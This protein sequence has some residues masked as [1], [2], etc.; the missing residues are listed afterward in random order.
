M[1]FVHIIIVILCVS[2]Y[3]RMSVIRSEMT[4]FRFSRD[5]RT[6]RRTGVTLVVLLLTLNA[7]FCCFFMTL[8]SFFARS[9]LISSAKLKSIFA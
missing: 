5:M 9:C 8:N 3:V 6:E 7:Y 4:P 2:I 1:H